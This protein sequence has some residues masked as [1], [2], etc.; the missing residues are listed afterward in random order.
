MSRA[1]AGTPRAIVDKLAV[2]LG[3]V[4][5][6]PDVKEKLAGQSAVVLVKAGDEFAAFIAAEKI[7]WDG[8]VKASGAKID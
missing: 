5:E 8:V 3:K 7:K 6:L 1:P 4:V 2:E